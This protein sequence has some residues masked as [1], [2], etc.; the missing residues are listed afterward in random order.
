MKL[1]GK[2][3]IVTGGAQGM[4]RAI[5]GRY[6]QEGASVVIADLQQA[7]AQQAAQEIGAG[8]GRAAAVAVD[9]RNQEQVQAMVAMQLG[10]REPPEPLDASDALAVALTRLAALRMESLL[11]RQA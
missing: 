1:Q 3:A 10:L 4:G 7:A 9:V 11:A 6:A 5:A 8:N 2:V